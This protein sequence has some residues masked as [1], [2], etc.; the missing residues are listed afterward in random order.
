MCEDVGSVMLEDFLPQYQVQ[1]WI[2]E[3]FLPEILVFESL[4]PFL[5]CHMLGYLD[6]MGLPVR[7]I[8]SVDPTWHNLTKEASL[9]WNLG[10]I[11]QLW[12]EDDGGRVQHNNIP[13]SQNNKHYQ[14]IKNSI[15]NSFKYSE[16]KGISIGKHRQPP[17]SFQSSRFTLA[18]LCRACSRSC[19]PLISSKTG[20]KCP[21]TLSSL[22]ACVG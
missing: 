21:L 2:V 16:I 8:D 7:I 14:M 9:S 20:S 1:K 18:L 5:G 12:S 13:E 17:S 22:Y 3:L 10:P 15:F 6:Y 19:E 11:F 4:G